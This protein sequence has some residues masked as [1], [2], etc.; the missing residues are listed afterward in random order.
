[1]LGEAAQRIAVGRDVLPASAVTRLARDAELTRL[2]VVAAFGGR[3]GASIRGV[4]GNA[5]VVPVALIVQLLRTGGGQKRLLHRCPFF[6][7]D[8]VGE[9]KLIQRAA[10]AGL[11]PVDLK[12]MRTREQHD[13]L[14]GTEGAVGRPG[15]FAAHDNLVALDGG[16]VIAT[17]VGQCESVHGRRE[18]PRPRLLRHAAVKRRV[19]ARVVARVAR[20]AGFRCDVIR[21][22]FLDGTVSR[23]GPRRARLYDQSAGQ[24][25]RPEQKAKGAA[26]D[27]R[28]REKGGPAGRWVGGRRIHAGQESGPRRGRKAYLWESRRARSPVLHELETL[29]M[30]GRGVLTRGMAWSTGKEW[31]AS[32]KKGR[33]PGGRRPKESHPKAGAVPD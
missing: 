11:S 5:A 30:G 27:A 28:R 8:D 15:G 23:L 32:Q 16:P 1:M 14:G 20:T 22:G 31:V 26:P 7:G 13:R 9:R 12:V 25:R 29:T 19:P 6:F 21:R 17:G 18:I 10:V 33:R 3:T 2:G 24:Q 4:A